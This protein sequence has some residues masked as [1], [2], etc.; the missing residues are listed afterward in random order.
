MA[1]SEK[2]LP[3]GTEL[4]ESILVLARHIRRLV[5]APIATG[6][7]VFGMTFL[8]TPS[9]IA[10]TRIL[11]PPQQTTTAALLANQVGQLAG[12]AAPTLGLKN[13]ADLYIGMIKSRTVADKLIARFELRE[14]Y[15]EKYNDDA[16]KELARRTKVTAGK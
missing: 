16:R 10:S 1:E 12:M 9:Y 4:L 3:Q 11:P 2:T 14:L 15:K 13:P 7:A 8:I 6:L 5:I